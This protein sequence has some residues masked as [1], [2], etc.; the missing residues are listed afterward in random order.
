M[1][2]EIESGWIPI[3]DGMM[4]RKSC[5]FCPVSF[6]TGLSSCSRPSP[7]ELF[8]TIP[9]AILQHWE[10]IPS[11]VITRHASNMASIF[12]FYSDTFSSSPYFNDRGQN[13]TAQ[14][15]T[16]RI[17]VCIL[18][19]YCLMLLIVTQPHSRPIVSYYFPKG[20]GAHHYGVSTWSIK[21]SNS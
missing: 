9:R 13:G 19:V 20:V 5:E 3:D 1:R 15:I 16:E 7:F 17:H 4:V 14:P 18:H 8:P 6:V 12:D 21:C 2:N 11:C 10:I